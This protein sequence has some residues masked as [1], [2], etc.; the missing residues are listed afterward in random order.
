MKQL[1]NLCFGLATQGVSG[2]SITSSFLLCLSLFLSLVLGFE[3]RA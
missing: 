1:E 3:L 2:V